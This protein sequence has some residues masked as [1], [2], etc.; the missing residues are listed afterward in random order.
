MYIYQVSCVGHCIVVGAVGETNWTCEIPILKSLLYSFLSG[1]F[2][3]HKADK[4]ICVKQDRN[5]AQELP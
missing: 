2:T 1:W 3:D 4:L 5:L